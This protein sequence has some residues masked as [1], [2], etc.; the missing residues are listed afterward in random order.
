MQEQSLT[1]KLQ[2]FKTA[3]ELFRERLAEDRN[4]LAA[5][6]IG[7]LDEDTIWRKESIHLWLIEADG[8]TRR[9]KY[10]GKNED[11]CRT[12]VENGVNIHAE[13]FPRSRFKQ[14][15]EGSS[16]TAFR[17]SFHAKREL[18]YSSDPGIAK[19]FESANSLAEHD[20]DRELLV[21]TTW[22][23]WS[24]RHSGKFLTIRN[25][26]ELT[27]Q[28]LMWAAHAL[29][30]IHIVLQG[31]VYEHEIIYRAIELDP[32]LFQVVYLDLISGKPTK[33]RCQAALD[34]VG[35]YLEDNAERFLKPMLH[36]LRKQRRTVPLS[37]LSDQFAH[38]QL[39]PWHLETAC[40]WLEERGHLEKLSA[41][42]ALTKKSR[43]E[44][45]EPAYMIES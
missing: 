17:H 38:S 13:L 20:Q 11:I 43:T 34:A 32:E 3:I 6:L 26:L 2:R 14:M 39:F 33:K 42:F 31:E 7:T 29:A 35:T 19:W 4:I 1:D 22:A 15:V 12:L 18:I 5:V 10:D 25:D 16:R 27:R 44:F 28:H 9:M 30:S 24:H 23:I 45:E 8:V 40:E 36:W 41:P 37:E 21:A